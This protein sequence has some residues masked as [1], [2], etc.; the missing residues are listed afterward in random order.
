MADVSRYC[1]RVD[2]KVNKVDIDHPHTMDVFI[3]D[4]PFSSLFLL[5]GAGV[6][7]TTDCPHRPAR[8]IQTVSFLLERL[9]IDTVSSCLTH[10]KCRV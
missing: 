3:S 10:I 5:K 1:H 8:Q 2:S 7:F 9:Y 4:I 6:A